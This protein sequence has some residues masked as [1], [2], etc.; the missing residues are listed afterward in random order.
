MQNVV[1]YLQ[2]SRN[3]EVFRDNTTNNIIMVNM[4]LF[5]A[6]RIPTK[7]LSERTTVTVLRM[8]QSINNWII[9]NLLS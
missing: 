5:K 8:Q 4:Y 3:S 7:Y 1:K 9:K 6:R 2:E